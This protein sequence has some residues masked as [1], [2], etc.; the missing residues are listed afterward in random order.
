MVGTDGSA[1]A[2]L[3][4]DHAAGLAQVFKARLTVVTAFPRSGSD[5]QARASADSARRRAEKVGASEV[6]TTVGGGEPA[7]VLVEAAK[8]LEADL[9][10]VGSKGMSSPS[11]FLLGSVP[12][13]VSHH[14]PC[15]LVIVRTAG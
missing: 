2:E 15:D 14:A 1:T 8:E 11:R 3:A 5:A 7:E 12:D 10:V 13:K 9:L 4:V 6:H